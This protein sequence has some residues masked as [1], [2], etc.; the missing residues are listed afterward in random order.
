MGLKVF[1]TSSLI[2]MMVSALDSSI[3]GLNCNVTIKECLFESCRC[4]T[5]KPRKQP[6]S[7]TKISF[8]AYSS[9]DFL[10]LSIILRNAAWSS[11][12]FS[13]NLY[14]AFLSSTLSPFS[15]GKIDF[16]VSRT[17]S[18]SSLRAFKSSCITLIS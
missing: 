15:P 3:S 2:F 7:G 14:S 11:L 8:C 13:S 17:I 1:S 9:T 5:F 16:R 18:N 10:N 4:S 6:S 12:S